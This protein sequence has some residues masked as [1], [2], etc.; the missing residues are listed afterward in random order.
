LLSD[1]LRR[2]EDSEFLLDFGEGEREF[3]DGGAW[4]STWEASSPVAVR[5]EIL[6]TIRDCDAVRIIAASSFVAAAAV[7]GATS[8]KPCG[9]D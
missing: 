7:C 8:P 9:V 6:G 3:G 4:A 2:D 5:I 1:R